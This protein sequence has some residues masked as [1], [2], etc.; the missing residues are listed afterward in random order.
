MLEHRGGELKFARFGQDTQLT[1][2]GDPTSLQSQA[3]AV[4]LLLGERI[5]S[6]SLVSAVGVFPTQAYRMPPTSLRADRV[7]AR[8]STS[9]TLQK[10]IQPSS[11]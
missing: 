2:S 5:N 3:Q 7:F 6:V 4:D 1:H 8:I 10:T 11:R 9:L